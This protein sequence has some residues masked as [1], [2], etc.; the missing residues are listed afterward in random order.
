[1]SKLIND[2]LDFTRGRLGSGMGIHIEPVAHIESALRD[3]VAE[4]RDAHPASTVVER[5]HLSGSVACDV[6]RVQQLLSNLLA[7]RSCTAV[8][9]RPSRSLQTWT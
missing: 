7:T 6:G 4:L 3:V 9:R 8:S 2:V 1:M 5:Y